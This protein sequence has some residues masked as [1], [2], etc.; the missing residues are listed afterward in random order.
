MKSTDA[1]LAS[2]LQTVI[3]AQAGI[4]G[5]FAQREGLDSRLRGNDGF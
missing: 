4:Q 3:P 1:I 5:T 2:R